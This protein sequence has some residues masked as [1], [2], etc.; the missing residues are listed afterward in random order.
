MKKLNL[1]TTIIEHRSGFTIVEILAVVILIVLIG[2]V[3]GGFCVGTY[4]KTLA[5][6]AA[7]DFVL[8]AKY[9]RITAI[10]QQSPCRIEIDKNGN[11]FALVLDELNQETGQTEQRTLRDLYFKPVEF[12]G[13]VKFEDIQIEPV[14]LEETLATDQEGAIVFSPSGTCRSTVVQIGDGKNHYA[15][16]ISASSGKVKMYTGTA[17]EVQID[18]KDLDEQ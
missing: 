14:G 1:K 11:R 9:A 10:E 15:I 8:A 7:R 6:K 16:S 3:G 12:S 17:E 2:S 18:T 5:R 4:K 13:D